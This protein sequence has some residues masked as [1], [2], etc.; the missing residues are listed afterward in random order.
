MPKTET[1][2]SNK[3]AQVLVLDTCNDLFNEASS[4][5]AEKRPVSIGAVI[6]YSDGTATSHMAGDLNRILLTG[7]L[8]D[9]VNQIFFECK[10]REINEQV[11]NT[12]NALHLA[13]MPMPSGDKTN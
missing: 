1:E 12:V 11:E 7:A 2:K 5:N 10:Q 4:D 3:K 8:T 13:S 6:I 9:L